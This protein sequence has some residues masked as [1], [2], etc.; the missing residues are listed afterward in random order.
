MASEAAEIKAARRLASFEG[1]LVL[2]RS[3]ADGL[4]AGIDATF[5]ALLA[6]T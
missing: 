1:L 4:P 5:G 6:P 3:D 2:A